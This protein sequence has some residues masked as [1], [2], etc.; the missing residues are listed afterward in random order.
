MRA[1]ADAG[2]ILLCKQATIGKRAGAEGLKGLQP[3]WSR[4]NPSFFGRSQQP[5]M[6]SEHF[7]VY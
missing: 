1:A 4:A 3:S 7:F 6:Y 5:K 2:A